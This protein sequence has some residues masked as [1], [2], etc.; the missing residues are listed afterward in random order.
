MT[1]GGTTGEVSAV[2]RTGI[3]PLELNPDTGTTATFVAPGSVTLYVPQGGIHGF[4]N[5]SDA[6]ASTSD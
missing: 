2:L 1:Y 3:E 6:P 4:G 5:H